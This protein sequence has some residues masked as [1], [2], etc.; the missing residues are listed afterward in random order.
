MPCSPSWSPAGSA[1]RPVPAPLKVSAQRCRSVADRGHPQ[2]HRAR[3]CRGPSP[4]RRTDAGNQDPDTRG[5]G[6]HGHLAHRSFRCWSVRRRDR[7]RSHRRVGRFRSR[8][9]YAAYSGIAP[10][11][12]SS[13]GHVVHRLSRRGNRKLN[14]AIHIAALSQIRH[15]HSDGRVLRPQDRRG[16]DHQRS[17]PSLEATYQRRHPRQL[18]VDTHNC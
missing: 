5:G 8:G 7:D 3:A 2:G 6:S 15:R 11:E 13:G 17:P 14:H 12:V 1:T 10:I 16:Q 4:P 18:L 9:H